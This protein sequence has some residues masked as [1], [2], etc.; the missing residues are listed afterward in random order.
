VLFVDLDGFK[1]VNDAFGHAVGDEVLRETAARLRSATRPQDTVARLAGDEFVVVCP[2]LTAEDEAVAIADRLSA[3]LAQPI[4][5]TD[6]DVAVSAS[7]GVAFA[8]S[9]STPEQVLHEA[10]TAMYRAKQLGRRRFEVYDAA[11]RTRASEGRRVRGLVHS[12]LAEDRVVVHYQPVVELA[13]GR[14]VGLEALM[15]LRD[16]DGVLLPPDRFLDVAADDGLLPALDLALLRAAAGQV[17][18][19]SGAYADGLDLT[20]NLCAGQLDEGV[21]DR[22]GTA[23][24]G[25]ALPPDRLVLDVTEQAVEVT[26][27]RAAERLRA[28]A[29]LGVRVAL[30]DVGR[31]AASLVQ[32]HRLPVSSL[33]IDGSLVA[34]LPADADGLVRALCGVAGQLGLSAHGEAVETDEQRVALAALGAVRG[35]GR[36]FGPPVPAA[37][38][39]A[40]LLAAPAPQRG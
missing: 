18:A 39:P 6:A 28:L 14:V 23:L 31:G 24:D 3:A 35:Q 11:L 26:G 16:R 37:Q 38:V 12:A 13:T 40:L 32:L 15:R 27:S 36:L 34:R 1:L 30:D 29:G 25:T 33:K 9:G 20:V 17:A 8:G 7:T 4:R 5:T 10:D 22:V 21:A 19:W 2:A